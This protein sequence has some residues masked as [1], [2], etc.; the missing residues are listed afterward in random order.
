MQLFKESI[1]VGFA[2]VGIVV[3]AGFA[4]AMANEGAT[5]GILDLNLE[6]AQK[7][8]DQ[9]VSDGGSAIA[10]AADVADRAVVAAAVAGER[11]RRPSWRRGGG[12]RGRRACAAA[13]RRRARARRGAGRG[14]S[15]A[16]P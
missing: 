16:Q 1:M 13:A 11:G 15:P 2:F 3:G 10:L 9:I 7:V 5:I 14:A 12:S 4:T 6:A 8:A